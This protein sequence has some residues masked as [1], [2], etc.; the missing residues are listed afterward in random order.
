MRTLSTFQVFV[1]IG[2][3][4][5]LLKIPLRN[6]M[7]IG[8]CP[9]LKPSTSSWVI[10]I[11]GWAVLIILCTAFLPDTAQWGDPGLHS[12]GLKPDQP[13]VE[14]TSYST[15]SRH[16]DRLTLLMFSMTSAWLTSL[17]LKGLLHHN[18]RYRLVEVPPEQVGAAL[19]E[20]SVGEQDRCIL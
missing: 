7:V 12:E 6:W 10:E 19:P 13:V 3:G 16:W 20:D 15:F 4:G 8:C 11:A 17:C 18:S 1:Y 5:R 14:L 2:A 9:T